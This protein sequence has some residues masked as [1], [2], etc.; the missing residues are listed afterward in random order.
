MCGCSTMQNNTILWLLSHFVSEKAII[1]K[2]QCG[3]VALAIGR[4]RAWATVPCRSTAL[5][6]VPRTTRQAKWT[7]GVSRAWAQ[8]RLPNMLFYSPL[9]APVLLAFFIFHSFGH[10]DQQ[11]G[12]TFFH[13][14]QW[15]CMLMNPSLTLYILIILIKS[16]TETKI[17]LFVF[18]LDRCKTWLGAAVWRGLRHL[19]SWVGLN[20]SCCRGLLWLLDTGCG[21]NCLSRNT[22]GIT[23]NEW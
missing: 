13:I 14:N 7:L 19:K 9:V 22:E 1:V 15:L 18:M 21:K 23:E 5:P 10:A 4:A 11:C 3:M 8:C 6:T 17:L 16:L 2:W 20:F 12:S